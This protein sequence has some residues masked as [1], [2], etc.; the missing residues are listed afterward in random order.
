MSKLQELFKKYGRLSS[1]LH[2]MISLARKLILVHS[3]AY[4]LSLAD[5]YVSE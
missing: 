2:H 5:D 3:V 1:R 4:I